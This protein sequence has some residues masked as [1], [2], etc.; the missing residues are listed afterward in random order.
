MSVL[1]DDRARR[2]LPTWRESQ[3]AVRFGE[4]TPA[5]TLARDRFPTSLADE[6]DLDDLISAF[7]RQPSEILASEIVA[8]AFVLRRTTGVQSAAD[9]L[10]SHPQLSQRLVGR[11]ARLAIG[12]SDQTG[13][14]SAETL[15]SDETLDEPEMS[16]AGIA[17]R[18]AEMKVR[19]HGDARNA[20]AWADL[21]RLYASLGQEEQAQ[22]SMSTAIGLA[23]FDRFVVRSA[24]RFFVRAGV[25]DRAAE[26]LRRSGQLLTDPWL[27]AAEIAV[28]TF[29]QRTSKHIGSARKL[30]ESADIAPRH[31]SELGGA[32]G[33]V[34]ANAGARKRAQRLFTQ[35]LREPTENVV[36]QAEYMVRVAKLLEPSTQWPLLERA[37]EARA[38]HEFGA[39]NYEESF[40]L[41]WSWLRDEPFSSRPAVLG[42]VIASMALGDP[43]RATR[44]GLAGLRSHPGSAV[45]LNN[46]AFALADAGRLDEARAIRARLSPKASLSG[47][48]A[49]AWSAT[50][51]LLDFRSGLHKDGRKKYEAALTLANSYGDD[52]LSTKVIAFWLAEE[53]RVRSA[54]AP[55]LAQRMVRALEL[56]VPASD[57]YLELA[58]VRVRRH[59]LY[60]AR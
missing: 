30:I 22:R 42:T 12:R 48:D 16:V 19:V 35:A 34:E 37:H 49:V 54:D 53:L 18:I 9:F 32:L 4:T 47:L 55:G 31:L 46:V 58:M 26:I 15:R 59:E 36:A 41:C 6:R 33:T 3:A 2:V 50:G 14:G 43:D 11:L 1:G 52:G 40:R 21:S 44:I 39:K 17:H 27:L 28:A 10:L 25:P 23:P 13:G 45:L 56:T 38:N 7:T 57:P 8:S 51:G 24:S 20:L 29:M 60:F 5:V